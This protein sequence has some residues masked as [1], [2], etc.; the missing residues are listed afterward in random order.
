MKI[1]LAAFAALILAASL[2]PGSFAKDHRPGSVKQGVPAGLS[3][4]TARRGTKPTGEHHDGTLTKPKKDVAMPSKE[5]P[6]PDAAVSK[7]PG[8]SPNA[9]IELKP[10]PVEMP[11]DHHMPG[12]A[13]APPLRNAIGMPVASSP[14]AT[15]GAGPH[16]QAP[17]ASI[18]SIGRVGVT[19]SSGPAGH[20][21][22]APVAAAASGKISGGALVRPH[23]PATGLAAVGGPARQSAAINGTAMRPKR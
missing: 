5:P 16:V 2:A 21:Q 22:V 6:L 4:S 19:S 1:R 12:P 8:T 3:K 10:K 15:P 7:G 9:A 11:R 23:N 13:N 17:P 20:A 18:G 14:P